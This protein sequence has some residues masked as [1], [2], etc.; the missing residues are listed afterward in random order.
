MSEQTQTAVS[1]PATPVIEVDR[2]PLVTWTPEQRA[3]FR[4][5]GEMPAQPKQEEAP[6]ASDAEK[7]PDSEAETEI[8]A[9]S[10]GESVTP[11]KPQEQQHTDKQSHRKPGAEK[12]I[13]ELTSEV[14]RLRAQL[15]ELKAKPATESK[16]AEKP[17]PVQRQPEPTRPKPTVEDKHPDGSNKYATYEDYV[18]DL[19]DWKSEQRIKQERQRQAATAMQR[20]FSAKVEDARSRY[21]KFDE[22]VSP[23]AEALTAQEIPLTI[24]QMLN[25]S[26]YLPDVL[27]TIG[28][29]SQEL[30]KFVKMAKTEP[31]KAIRYLALTESLIH[32][33]LSSKKSETK[34][35]PET[36]TTPV[37]KQTSA[38]PPPAE[39]GGRSTTPPDALETAAQSGDFRSFKAEAN[40]RY[41]DRLSGR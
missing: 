18:E 19:A 24:R 1:S 40:R 31:G 14:K 25:D 30:A 9:E 15:D 20:E 5:T 33:E 16:Q 26:E 2:G 13:G 12:R 17:A 36:T 35:K 39:V 34:A 38:P 27:F 22:V 7:D 6:A 8:E 29:D 11:K 10:E 41:R 37:K 32:E 3:E 4:R 23:A 21:E 28:S